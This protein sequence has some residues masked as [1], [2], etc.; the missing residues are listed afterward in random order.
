MLWES[1]CVSAPQS[2]SEPVALYF[3]LLRGRGRK[4]EHQLGW[5][6]ESSFLGRGWLPSPAFAGVCVLVSPAPVDSGRSGLGC[7]L[8][9]SFSPVTSRKTSL[10]LP[11]QSEVLGVRTSTRDLQGDA[12]QP[13]DPGQCD[14]RPAGRARSRSSQDSTLSSETP[15]GFS[16]KHVCGAPALCW[17]L[18]R[19]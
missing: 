16:H 1:L 14:T 9:S 5:S 15:A 3:L 18:G 10:Q 19:Q 13:P 4:S 7:T 12:V 6:P 11:S 17:A 8:R 2:A